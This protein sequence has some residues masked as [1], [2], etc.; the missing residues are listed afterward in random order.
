MPPTST[1][2]SAPSPAD[3]TALLECSEARAYADLFAG[4]GAGFLAQPVGSALALAAD[5]LPGVV[6]ANRVIAL[7][8]AAQAT[9]DELDQL[10]ALYAAR[11]LG[12]GVELAPGA[13]PA[14][15]LAGWLKARR[16][17]RAMQGKAMLWRDGSPPPPR[18]EKWARAT[19]LRVE[20]V[21]EEGAHDLARLCCENFQMPAA[22]LP[23]L[24]VGTRGHR[25]RRWLAFDGDRPVGGSLS[26]VEGEVA[27][28]GWTSVLPSHRGRWVHAGIVARELDD[29]AAAGCRWVTTETAPSTAERPDAAH[30]NLRQFGFQE[31]YVR[32]TYLRQPPAAGRVEVPA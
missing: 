20:Q 14:Q 24:L 17:R 18:Y 22:T 29:V 21:G 31:A 32:Q 27:W 12:F 2:A 26:Y 28:L 9:V 15:E 3:L 13:Q 30:H 5:A 4:A 19:G 7:G 10:L 25:W 1:D 11:G 23:L 6:I 8:A 16:M